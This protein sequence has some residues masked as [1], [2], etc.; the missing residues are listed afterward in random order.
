[1][2]TPKRISPDCPVKSNRSQV[3]IS[4][5]TLLCAVCLCGMLHTAEIV[6]AV[7]YTPPRLTPRCVAHRRG[8]LRS[9]LHTA[10]LEPLTPRYVAH[11]GDCL[12]SVMHTAKIDSAVCCTPPRSS[13]WC[14][15]RSSPRCVAHRGDNCGDNFV[16]EYLDIIETEFEN[17]LAW[18]S[19]AHMGSNPEK[20]TGRDMSP[21]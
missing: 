5:F 9:G 8:C 3:K 1:M 2:F 18:L 12:C 11:R 10:D 13:P 16:I 7:C 21:C 14:A 4:I 15:Q 17:T 6:S 19:G 20:K